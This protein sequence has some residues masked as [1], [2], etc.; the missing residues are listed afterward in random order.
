VYWW[1]AQIQ[2]GTMGAARAINKASSVLTKKTERV[3]S[4]GRK[5][6]RK[7]TSQ[8][9]LEMDDDELDSALGAPAVAGDREATS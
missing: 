1:H 9:L 7:G 8:S 2:R 6:V 4:S 5:D 3:A